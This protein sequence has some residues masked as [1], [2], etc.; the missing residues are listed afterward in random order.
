MHKLAI[1][2]FVAS[3]TNAFGQV[4][5]QTA[6][7]PV[8]FVPPGYVVTEK[9]HGDLNKDGQADSVLIIKGTDKANFVKD[10]SRGELDRNRRGIIIAFRNN[11]RYELALKNLN[12]FSSE[13]EDGGVYFSP[14]LGVFIEKGILRVHYFHGRYG[15]WAYKFRYQNSDFE[16][17]GYD[18]SQN[19][20]PV[21]EQAV[22]IN[23][24]SNKMLIKENI[25]AEA[26]GDEKFKETWKKLVLSKLIKLRDISDFDSLDVTSLLGPVK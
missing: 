11:D 22:S 19:R 23:F 4:T 1:I 6:K 20:G 14:E 5:S 3:V 25:N 26:G 24:M 2:I 17:I 16:L 12:C 15:F 9:I 8:K 7:S 18:S 13:N 21:T 10:E